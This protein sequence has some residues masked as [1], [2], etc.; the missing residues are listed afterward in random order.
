MEWIEVPFIRMGKKQEKIERE[1]T[2]SS[3]LHIVVSEI[4]MSSLSE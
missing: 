2:G 1:E 3:E 4:P